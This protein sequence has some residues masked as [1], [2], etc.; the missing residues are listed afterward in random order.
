MKRGLR[1]TSQLNRQKRILKLRQKY[2]SQCYAVALC[3]KC[4]N[5]RKDLMLHVFSRD[6][7]RR[8]VLPLTTFQSTIITGAPN[9]GFLLNTLITLFRLSRVL[10]DVQKCILGLAFM[11]TSKDEIQAVENVHYIQ[12]SF[13]LPLKRLTTW[14][15]VPGSHQSCVSLKI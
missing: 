5:N 2:F 6:F 10:L 3:N 12:I 14:L 7:C 13:F 4:S 15:I 9:N 11:L 1:V 8:L